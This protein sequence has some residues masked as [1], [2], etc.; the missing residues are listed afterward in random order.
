[1]NIQSKVSYITVGQVPKAVTL[2]IV[3]QGFM[4]KGK[5]FG[6][7]VWGQSGVGKNAVTD[8]MNV[9]FTKSTGKKWN[10]F[11]CN[12]SAMCPEDITGL[13]QID[14]HGQTVDRPRYMFPA[15]SF[16]IFR[17]DEFDRPAYR[18]NHV[19]IVKY[20]IDK[21]VEKPLP[22]NWFVL[23]LA[24]GMSDEGTQPLTEHIK[25]RF[26]HLYVSTNSAR[27]KKEFAQYIDGCDMPEAIKRMN[28]L[29][30]L[31][32]RDEFEE[33]A[34]YNSRSMQYAASILKAYEALKASGA[35]FNDVLLPVLA[36]T[37][38]RQAAVELVKLYDLS[39]MPTLD[40]VIANPLKA[41][42]PDDL[43]LR[44]RFLDVL[45]HEATADCDKSAKLVAYLVRYPDEIAR[46]AMDKL[47]IGCPDVAK[48]AAYVKWAN[49]SR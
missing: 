42:M 28:K 24:N 25:G 2:C 40:E 11:D 41:I 22:E 30:P 21:T 19:A 12:L 18:Q 38:G 6:A 3:A 23:G 26:V 31:E 17:C 49:R 32:T 7:M 33:H 1:M 35:D 16:G 46:Y 34:V 37:V 8:N 45:V 5:R 13:P 39:D 20:A 44:H 15:D 47:V 14:E 48:T 29:N 10:M 27:A 36:G 9:S 4:P 43:S